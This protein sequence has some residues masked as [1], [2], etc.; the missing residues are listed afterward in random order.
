MLKSPTTP[1]QARARQASLGMLAD[2]EVAA[3]VHR[4]VSG[5]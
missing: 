5:E 2:D 3:A 1:D 4:R